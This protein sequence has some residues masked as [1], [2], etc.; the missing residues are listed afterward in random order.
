MTHRGKLELEDT[1]QG[2]EKE[3]FW[4]GRQT[5]ERTFARETDAVH[6][7]G[8]RIYPTKYLGSQQAEVPEQRRKMKKV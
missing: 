7:R 8:H 6:L 2:K 5:S 3:V 1:T 4:V